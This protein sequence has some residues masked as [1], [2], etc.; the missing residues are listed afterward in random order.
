MQ[1][2]LHLFPYWQFN[3]LSAFCWNSRLLYTTR[4]LQVDGANVSIRSGIVFFVEV[5]CN[6]CIASINNT[7]PKDFFFADLIHFKYWFQFGLLVQN[8]H[9]SIKIVCFQIIVPQYYN[10]N[11]SVS[12]I[13]WFSLKSNYTAIINSFMTEAVII[14]KPVHSFAEQI[15]GLVSL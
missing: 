9:F 10:F 4:Y 12:P 3:T 13:I 11:I 8:S 1:G 5:T 15:N 2:G 7:P 6:L 14:Q